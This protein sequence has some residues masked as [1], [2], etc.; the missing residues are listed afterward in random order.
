MVVE[1]VVDP[2]GQINHL[3]GFGNDFGATAKTSE[4]MADVAVILL[5]RES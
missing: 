1:M 5:D 2:Q 4:E 3:F